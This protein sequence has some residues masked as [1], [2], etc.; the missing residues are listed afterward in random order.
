MT[1]TVHVVGLGLSAALMLAMTQSAAGGPR[2]APKLTVLC[3]PPGSKTPT[4]CST[5]TRETR[6]SIQLA[7]DG[8]PAPHTLL[9]REVGTGRTVPVKLQPKWFI[10][11]GMVPVQLPAELCV[12]SS[13]QAGA[14]GGQ[15]LQFEIQTLTSDLNNA[16]QADSVGF[17][18]MRCN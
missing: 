10:D 18:Q 1:L 11:H 6:L 7:K 17:F 14:R 15:Q 8:G 16:Q 2:K 4:A 12:G 13:R 3:L 9:L 5:A